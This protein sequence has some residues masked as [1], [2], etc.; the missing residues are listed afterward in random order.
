MSRSRDRDRIWVRGRV[1]TGGRAR[2]VTGAR[3][4]GIVEDREKGH[5]ECGDRQPGARV[6]YGTGDRGRGRVG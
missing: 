6:G 4:M 3:G 2:I 1:G 5:A